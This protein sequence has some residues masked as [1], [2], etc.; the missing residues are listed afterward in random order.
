MNY[1]QSGASIAYIGCFSAKSCD[2]YM[3]N[4][5]IKNDEHKG[6]SIGFYQNEIKSM[7][8]KDH[9]GYRVSIA[10]IMYGRG[11]I[12]EIKQYI[13]K[14]IEITEGSSSH[15]FESFGEKFISEKLRNWKYT[16]KTGKYRQEDEYRIILEIPQKPPAGF[17]KHRFEKKDKDSILYRMKEYSLS[18]IYFVNMENKEQ[19]QFNSDIRSKGYQFTEHIYP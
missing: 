18:D 1:M 3:I 8:I 15:Y 16:S 10:P 6:I 17:Y 4:N 12:E 2:P 13:R 7:G 11:A 9:Y 19:Q 14:L 5:Y